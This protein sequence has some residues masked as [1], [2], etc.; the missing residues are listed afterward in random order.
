[1][2]SWNRKYLESHPNNCNFTPWWVLLCTTMVATLHSKRC[3]FASWWLLFCMASCN[4]LFES[5]VSNIFL[6]Y[7][8]WVTLCRREFYIPYE[9]ELHSLRESTSFFTG[10]HL[11]LIRNVVDSRIG[12]KILS[13]GNNYFPGLKILYSRQGNA[14]INVRNKIRAIFMA[15][16]SI[17]NHLIVK[18]GVNHHKR[19][20]NHP[21]NRSKNSKMRKLKFEE[22]WLCIWRR[23]TEHL[24]TE[25]GKKTPTHP[26]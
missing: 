5:Q 25:R 8:E 26:H 15:V 9:N 17:F 3:N 24:K 20:V 23:L 12:H 22:D 11:I 13:A 16:Q 1:M 21:K 14:S 19:E 10:I 4:D 6:P 7:I 18:V 2:P